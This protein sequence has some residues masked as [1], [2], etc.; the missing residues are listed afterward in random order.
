MNNLFQNTITKE[1]IEKL[2]LAGFTGAIHMV[3]N[4]SQVVKAIEHLSQYPFIGF[5][6]ETKP[7]FKKGKS[8]KVSLVQLSTSTDAYLFRL[9][10]IGLPL[11]LCNLLGDERISKVGLAVRDDLN[12]MKKI[13]LFEPKNVIDLQTLVKEYGIED[14]SLKKIAAIV[15]NIRITKSQQTSNW[16]IEELTEAQLAYAATDAWACFEIY[17]KIKSM[18]P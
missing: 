13:R 17:A 4:E 10:K 15:M 14:M 11:E 3:D 7:S 2:P 12:A 1:E 18:T 16:E 8:N 9:N 6:T 5:D